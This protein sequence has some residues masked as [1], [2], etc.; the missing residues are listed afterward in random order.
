MT[1]DPR[2][3]AL[4]RRILNKIMRRYDRRIMSNPERAQYVECLVALTLGE[5][6]RLTRERDGWDWAAWDCQHD[7]GA[8]LEVKQAAARQSW[9]EE[10]SVPSRSPRFDIAPRTGY[11]TRDG[12]RWLDSPGR[13]ADLFVFAWHHERRYEYADQRDAGQWRFFVVAERNL[14]R[15]QRSIGLRKLNA[16]APPCLIAELGAAVEGACP[17]RGALKA[18]LGHA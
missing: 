16:L 17:P 7:S 12:S 14:P 15:G 6:W 5:D 10:V 2:N 1:R 4:H 9:D 11:W 18:A 13:Q 3:E 8:R